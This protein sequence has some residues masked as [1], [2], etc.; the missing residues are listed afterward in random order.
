M[1]YSTSLIDYS[2]QQVLWALTLK[3]GARSYDSNPKAYNE[4]RDFAF[5]SAGWKFTPKGEYHYHN[6]P[7][8]KIDAAPKRMLMDAILNACEN[9]RE[10]D[11][12]DDRTFMELLSASME[13][14]ST[15]YTIQGEYIK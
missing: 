13:G 14:M 11:P 8:A 6:I 9:F 2:P 10:N 7:Q 4:I 1:I 5:N 3:D 15:Q 12:N